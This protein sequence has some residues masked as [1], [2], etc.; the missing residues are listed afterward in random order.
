MAQRLGYLWALVVVHSSYANHVMQRL[1]EPVPECG[2]NL[3]ICSWRR[4]ATSPA[5][6]ESG[7]LNKST[8]AGV[9]DF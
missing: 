5:L 8:L 1:A 7:T 3:D 2:Q 9:G 4:L 6:S